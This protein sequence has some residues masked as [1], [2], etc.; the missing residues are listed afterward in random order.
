MSQAQDYLHDTA[1][2]T[3]N[4]TSTEQRL[5]QGTIKQKL[6]LKD[7][8]KRNMTTKVEKGPLSSRLKSHKEV[9]R[10]LPT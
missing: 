3:V 7:L 6:L 4:D 9:E 8:A 1:Q 10:V 5:I 2:S